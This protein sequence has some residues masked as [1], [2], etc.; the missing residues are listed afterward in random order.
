MKEPKKYIR[1]IFLMIVISALVLVAERA[2]AQ[3][4][5]QGQRYTI[6]KSAP[7]S[8]LKVS[9]N[10]V[11]YR[12]HNHVY[13]KPVKGKHIVVSAPLGIRVKRLPA[14]ASPIVV[15]NHVYYEY[16]GSYYLAQDEEYVVVQAPVGAL[17]EH[18]PE[19][20]EHLEIN[21]EHYYVADGVQYKAVLKGDELWYEVI[22]VSDKAYS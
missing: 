4:R 7:K 10:N 22:K 13:Y 3:R 11:E 19:E 8:S 15:R 1:T 12:V 9:Y 17:V 16:Q 2:E 21:G 20:Y 6:V 14:A 5:V 18:L